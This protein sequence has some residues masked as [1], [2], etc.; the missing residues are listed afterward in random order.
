M[1]EVV[2]WEGEPY[3]MLPRGVL[4]QGPDAWFPGQP[5]LGILYATLANNANFRDARGPLPKQKITLKIGQLVMS[6][7]G[8]SETHGVSM[9][10]LRT[11]MRLIENLGKINTQTNTHGTIVTIIDYA[12]I[13]LHWPNDQHTHQ[14]TPNTRLTQSGEGDR[15]EKGETLLPPVVPRSP[16]DSPDRESPQPLLPAGQ[17]PVAK[18]RKPPNPSSPTPQTEDEAASR[19]EALERK[20]EKARE[21]RAGTR[22]RQL[23]VLAI[24]AVFNDL[25]DA[26][27]RQSIGPQGWRLLMVKFKTFDRYRNAY[28][29]ANRERVRGGSDATTFEA[30]LRESFKALLL[31]EQITPKAEK[32]TLIQGGAD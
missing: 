8:Y 22:A 5:A 26:E 12:R 19:L 30:Q 21:R 28:L 14:H 20:S 7:R 16:G 24:G 9:Q 17:K 2:K 23:T 18:R 29:K 10:N 6:L 27:A 25:G 3:I 1:D 32:L 4:S 13:F 31:A 15:P 11:Q